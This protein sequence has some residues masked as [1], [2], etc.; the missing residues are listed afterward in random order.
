MIGTGQEVHEP[1]ETV[2][3]P[4]SSRR[5]NER[6]VALRRAKDTWLRS[7]MNADWILREPEESSFN[8]MTMQ[9]MESI[10]TFETDS[11]VDTRVKTG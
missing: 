1:V 3:L 9:E 7:I 5:I 11:R 10:I 2:P 4:N 8:L 6:A